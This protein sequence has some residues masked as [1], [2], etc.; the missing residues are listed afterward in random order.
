MLLTSYFFVLG[1]FALAHMV[2]P[3][4]L[5]LIPSAVPMIPFHLKFTQGE[6]DGFEV[7]MDYNFNTHDLI[8]LAASAGV[9]VWYILKK[10]WVANNL[11]GLAFAVNGVELLHLSNVV[12]GC[13]L[14]GGLFFYDIFWVFGTDVMVTV[15][16]SFEAP[17]KL[18]FPQDL[19]ENGPMGATNFAMLGLGDIVIPGIFIA[20]LLRYDNSL[21]R[22][23]NF[24]FNA[25]FIAYL[26]GLLLTIFVM[27][28]Y[29]HAQPALLYLVPACLG[30]PLF[31]ALVRGDIKSMF[32]YEDHPNVEEKK[33]N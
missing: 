12:T 30:V 25:T 32:Q 6:G 27:H 23:S 24:Y 29:K 4:L 28:V 2:S 18:V 17:I 7:I 3:L 5:K 16:K 14:L 26:A 21:K 1:I 20:L 11:L 15:A 9:G 31:P 33:T 10:H 22:S 13:I 8:C 19:L